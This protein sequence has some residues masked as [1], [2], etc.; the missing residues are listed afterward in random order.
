MVESS[1]AELLA[2]ERQI[3]RQHHELLAD[4]LAELVVDGRARDKRIDR[5]EADLRANT[6]ATQSVKADTASL[7]S[8]FNALQGGF[9][10]LEWLGKASATLFKT[11]APIAIMYGGW[12]AF[13]AWLLAGGKPP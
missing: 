1:K 4:Q 9:S 3:L 13:K 2:H 5:M 6:V 7:V 11:G 8:A 12:V 10:V